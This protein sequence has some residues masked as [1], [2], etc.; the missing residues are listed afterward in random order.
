[1]VNVGIVLSQTVLFISNNLG[2]I[3]KYVFLVYVRHLRFFY[4]VITITVLAKQTQLDGQK[5]FSG[6]YRKYIKFVETRVNGKQNLEK[7][8]NN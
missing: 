3:N 4:F 1:M 6:R 5:V 8:V 7:G 2:L